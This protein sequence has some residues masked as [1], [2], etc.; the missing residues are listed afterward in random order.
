[1]VL[2]RSQIHRSSA[3]V[4]EMLGVEAT[5]WACLVRDCA[6]AAGRSEANIKGYI[7]P[8]I[9]ARQL[10]ASQTHTSLL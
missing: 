8:S 1:M 4:T 6:A 7:R 10:G 9:V 3:A 2:P 5:A